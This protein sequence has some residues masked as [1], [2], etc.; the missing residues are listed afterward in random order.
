VRAEAIDAYLWN[1]ADSAEAKA[2]LR[3][4]VQKG[5]EIFVDALDELPGRK[6][7]SFNAK[8]AA[9]LKAHPR[10]GLLLR[11]R[12]KKADQR[13]EQDENYLRRRSFETTVRRGQA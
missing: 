11:R 6:Q 4:Y 8:L 7:K 5:E 3:K 2:T 1:H 9:F 13:R 12:S 10:S